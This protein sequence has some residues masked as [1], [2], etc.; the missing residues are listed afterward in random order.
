MNIFK[1]PITFWP[2]WNPFKL[3]VLGALYALAYDY[4][5]REFVDFFFPLRSETYHAITDSVLF[6]YVIL[7]SFPFIFYKGLRTVASSFSL[8]TY[9]LAYIPVL[10]ALWCYSFSKDIQIEYS[11]VF[12]LCMCAF[13]L[14]DRIYLLKSMFKRKTGLIPFKYLEYSVLFV[15]I[16]LVILNRSQLTF[17]NFL[18]N[19]AELYDARAEMNVKGI[20]FVCWMRSCFLP[21]IMVTS[22]RERNLR[23]YLLVLLGF[24]LIFMLD[25]QKLTAVFPL[26]VTGLF[27]V[28]NTSKKFFTTY[29]HSIIIIILAI[30]SIAIVL[31]VIKTNT[32]FSSNPVLFAIAALF[33]MRTQCIEGMETVRYFSFFIKDG[34]PFTYYSHVNVINAVTHSYPYQESIGATVAGDGGVSNATFWLMDGVAAMGISGVFIISILFIIFKSIM[35]SADLRCS[36]PMYVCISLQGIMSMMNLSLFTS[37][38]TCGLLMLYLVLLFF[39]TNLAPAPQRLLTQSNSLK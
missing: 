38:N 29:F 15:M 5:Y 26:V 2:S 3:L 32:T 18:Q 11:I 25:K 20:Y 31:Y 24:I 10:N 39:K 14:T 30:S 36:V 34:N 8:F 33:V 28:A 22:L 35:N 16:V 13:F 37:I 7:S 6:L 4:V 27:F 12:F 17:V 9:I 21:L 23:K 19:S 1:L